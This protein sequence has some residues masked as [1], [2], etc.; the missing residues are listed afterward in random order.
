[1]TN[2][3]EI[4]RNAPKGLELYSLICGKVKLYSVKPSDEYP[5]VVETSTKNVY[6][7]DEYGRI[8][9]KGDCLLFPSKECKLW[10]E[11][12]F[13]LLK[14]GHFITTAMGLTFYIKSKLNYDFKAVYKDGS[15]GDINSITTF[16]FASTEEIEHFYVEL[17]KNGYTIKNGELKPAEKCEIRLV[18]Y[19]TNIS[20]SITKAKKT[21]LIDSKPFTI[22]DFKPFDKVL[23][24]HCGGSWHIQ[25]FSHY[26]TGSSFPYAC[27][28]ECKYKHCVPYNDETKHL[29]ET[30]EEYNGKYKTW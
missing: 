24:K 14:P 2:L 20:V 30:T 27:L 5:I 25:F 3:V 13:T 17:R 11:W 8:N 9:E 29:L 18:G 16:R 1:M 12:Q 21:T 19:P 10:T 4:L 23:V 22:D 26:N 6:W 7:F 28:F 15:I